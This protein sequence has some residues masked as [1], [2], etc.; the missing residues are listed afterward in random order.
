MGRLPTTWRN[1]SATHYHQI[2]LYPTLCILLRFQTVTSLAYNQEIRILRFVEIRRHATPRLLRRSVPTPPRG[3]VLTQLYGAPKTSFGNKLLCQT[4]PLWTFLLSIGMARLAFLVLLL[5][6]G[7]IGA[8]SAPLK[9][10]KERTGSPQL[11]RP[12]FSSETLIWASSASTASLPTSIPEDFQ[13]KRSQYASLGSVVVTAASAND[14]D[15][16]SVVCDSV[17]A[18][19]PVTSI[20]LNGILDGSGVPLLTMPSCIYDILGTVNSFVATKLIVKGNSTH[21]DPLTLIG[22]IFSGS[23]SLFRTISVDFRGADGISLAQVDWTNF[24]SNYMPTLEMWNMGTTNFV[25]TLPSSLP[26]SCTDFEMTYTS[27]TGTIPS[28]MLP[29][30]TSSM[31]LSVQH[32]NLSGDFPNGFFANVGYN[33][34]LTVIFNYNQM[35]GSIPS[36]SLAGANMASL[37]SFTLNLQQ[38]PGLTGTIPTDLWGLP[39][40][41]AATTMLIDVGYTG[42]KAFSKT[43]LSTY[44]FP[45][46]VSFTF[47]TRYS[48]IKGDLPSRIMPLSAPKLSSYTFLNDGNVMGGTVPTAFIG[49]IASWT[50]GASP[51]TFLTLWLQYNQLTGIITFPAAPA[52]TLGSGPYTTMK[53]AGQNNNFTYMNIQPTANRYLTDIEIGYSPGSRGTLDNVFSFPTD[54]SFMGVVDFTNCSI[55][56]T[57]PDLNTK[58]TT[59]IGW[60]ALS[61]TQIDFCSNTS[62]SPWTG[63]SKLSTCLLNGTN[64]YLCPELYP[65]CDTSAPPPSAPTST[66]SSPPSCLNSTKPSADFVCVDGIWINFD[67]FTT[68]TL[69]I[70]TSSTSGSSSSGSTSQVLVLGNVTSSRIAYQHLG[71]QL[72]VGGCADN[73]SSI[74]VELSEGDL[75]LISDSGGDYNQLLLSTQ[76]SNCSDLSNVTLS[77]TTSKPICSSVASSTESGNG[78]LFALFSVTDASCTP[79]KGHKAWII[80]VPAVCGGVLLIVILTVIIVTCSSGAKNAVRPYAGSDPHGV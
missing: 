63:S 42:M 47:R 21:P 78:Q 36:N 77:T 54:F 66:P 5:L 30:G 51:Y 62:R 72:V 35:S 15:F 3:L 75:K 37:Q 28:T 80:V 50:G 19:A 2:L 64:A 69:V 70:T 67:S 49:N 13:E 12:A 43:F 8:S 45:N 7:A 29:V 26:I 32:A 48:A 1:F 74:T 55:S 58:N 9:A 24:V 31:Y 10:A 73:V 39:T 27:F 65:N 25:G 18:N 34:A 33:A 40:P 57:M 76:G 60:L 23:L 14:T 4:N 22:P 41:C 56:G 11:M 52:Q 44:S 79:T 59:N 61:N 46:L 38:N 71:T 6:L 53:F 17:A 16:E 68:P 20:Q